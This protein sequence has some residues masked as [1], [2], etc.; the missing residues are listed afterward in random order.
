MTTCGPSSCNPST[1]LLLLFFFIKFVTVFVLLCCCCC[2]CHGQGKGGKV[3]KYGV[4]MPQVSI[5][6]VVANRSSATDA[7]ICI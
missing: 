4:E 3:A 6:S 5:R 2:P 7:P 1:L